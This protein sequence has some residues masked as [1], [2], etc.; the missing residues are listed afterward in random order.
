[1]TPRYIKSSEI[2]VTLRSENY[3]RCIA[4]NCNGRSVRRQ[5]P[6]L[7]WP[8]RERDLIDPNR[9]YTALRSQASKLANPG[10][11]IGACCNDRLAQL[12]RSSAEHPAERCPQYQLGAFDFCRHQRNSESDRNGN[13]HASWTH[14][15]NYCPLWHLYKQAENTVWPLNVLLHRTLSRY[16]LKDPGCGSCSKHRFCF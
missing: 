5:Q 10:A 16:W 9:L 4:P 12:K 11:V 13:V 15:I 7:P 1:M 2:S 8:I 6:D 3:F 14:R